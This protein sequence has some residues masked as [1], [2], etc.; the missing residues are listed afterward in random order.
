M[1]SVITNYIIINW[2]KSGIKG[3]VRIDKIRSPL[4][5]NTYPVDKYNQQLYCGLV[6][7]TIKG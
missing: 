1:L 4:L 6:A 5:N 3:A 7:I 2:Y